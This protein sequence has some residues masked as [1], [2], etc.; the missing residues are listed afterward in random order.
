MRRNKQRIASSDTFLT[1]I[2][3]VSYLRK[4]LAIQMFP[5][6]DN[7]KLFLTGFNRGQCSS[8]IIRIYKSVQ[9][10][11]VNSPACDFSKIISLL[12]TRM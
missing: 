5:C 8:K 3:V 1:P 10:K 11:T 2:T 12:H 7:I 9:M 4:I 6:L